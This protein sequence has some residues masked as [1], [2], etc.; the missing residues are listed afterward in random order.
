MSL[1]VRR[2]EFVLLNGFDSLLIQTHPKRSH[3]M[4]M[5]RI[6]LCI[7]DQ[8]HQADALVLRPARFIGKLRVDGEDQLRSGDAPTWVHQ[9]ATISAAFARSNTAAIA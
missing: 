1:V 4:D 6:A 5:L 9:A 2:F 3:D 7:D 8:R